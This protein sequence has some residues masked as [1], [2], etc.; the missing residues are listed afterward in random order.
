MAAGLRPC[1]IDSTA[2]MMFLFTARPY[3]MMFLLTAR[4]YIL[5]D[6]PSRQRYVKLCNMDCSGHPH[7]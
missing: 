2:D 4:P 6:N 1:Y 3:N 5:P 7:E